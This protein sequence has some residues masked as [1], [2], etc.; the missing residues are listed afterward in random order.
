VQNVVDGREIGKPWDIVK[1]CTETDYACLLPL[2]EYMFC[3]PCTSAPVE[4]TFSYGGLFIRQIRARLSA[5]WLRQNS[6][7][8]ALLHFIYP[9]LTVVVCSQ[10]LMWNCMS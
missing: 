2:F 9:T 1:C 8:G 3:V 4:Y 10:E 5:I 7:N 6:T